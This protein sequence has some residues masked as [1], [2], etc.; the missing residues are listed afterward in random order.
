MPAVGQPAGLAR[1]EVLIRVR[2]TRVV[3]VPELILGAVRIGVAPLPEELDELLTLLFVG[4]VLERMRLFVR[5]D[6]AHILVQ[7]L[8]VFRAQLVA[9]RFATLKLF[10]VTQAS[11]ERIWLFLHRIALRYTSI[12]VRSGRILSAKSRRRIQQGEQQER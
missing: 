1:G 5:N 6:P 2:D 3:F 12:V 9:D 7:P 11:L 8:L 4:Q 10:L